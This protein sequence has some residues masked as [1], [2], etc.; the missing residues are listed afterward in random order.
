MHGFGE[1]THGKQLLVLRGDVSLF[2]QHAVRYASEHLQL[3]RSSPRKRRLQL[4]PTRNAQGPL[5]VSCSI[6][7]IRTVAYFEALQ[8]VHRAGLC[9]FVLYSL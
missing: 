3:T 2:R 4:H 7:S 1:S 9:D 5:C 8:A 6:A